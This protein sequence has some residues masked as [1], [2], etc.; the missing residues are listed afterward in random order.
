MNNISEEM[1]S[2]FRNRLL[3]EYRRYNGRKDL[4]SVPIDALEVIVDNQRELFEQLQKQNASVQDQN[5]PA[6]PPATSRIGG[7]D[8][9][10]ENAA[11]MAQDIANLLASEGNFLDDRIPENELL[12][13]SNYLGKYA[14][15]PDSVYILRG[16]VL[17]DDFEE[18][19]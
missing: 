6:Q 9:A 19:I 14:N 18:M 12:K 3:A 8:M 7:V 15:D 2:K 11:L 17:G 10:K 1:E 4:S 5:S 13:R 16:N